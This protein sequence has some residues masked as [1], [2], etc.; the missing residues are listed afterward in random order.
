[1]GRI[2][3]SAFVG[4]ALALVLGYFMIPYLKRLKFGQYIREE[5]PKAH[6]KK[7]GTPTMGGIFILLPI[8]AASFIFNKGD[9]AFTLA[10]SLVTL[11]YGLLGFLD[12]YLK[13]VKKQSEGLKPKQKLLGEFGLGLALGLFVYFNPSLG[14]EIY[15]PIIGVTV[16]IGILIIP[17]TLF[18]AVSTTNAVNLTDGVDG[19]CS[20]VTLIVMITFILVGGMAEKAALSSGSELAA[21]GI[22]NVRIF[23]AAAAG[24]LAAFLVYN[25]HPAKVF[26]GDTGS[27]GLGGVVVSSAVLLKAPFI[28]LLVGIVY[29]AETLSDIIQVSYYKKTKKRVFLMA[30]IHHHYELKGFSE[31]RIVAMFAA[32][33]A[34]FCAITVLFY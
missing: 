7:A 5:G 11:G 26:M 15:F 1:M 29:V 24:A 21:V 19:L 9:I 33:T 13:V 8:V 23:A 28:I 18:A 27:L 31:V 10:A 3:L 12:D 22:G 20:S 30:P 32:V 6:L 2:L 14:G 34:V 4:F 25:F 16:N 17:L